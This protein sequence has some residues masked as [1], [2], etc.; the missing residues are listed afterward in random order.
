MSRPAWPACA[1]RVPFGAFLDIRDIQSCD[2]LQIVVDVST[3]T[4]LG[5]HVDSSNHAA[6]TRRA[7]LRA[8]PLGERESGPA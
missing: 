8:S 1:I 5:G 2:T 6:N 4:F 7:D 3:F